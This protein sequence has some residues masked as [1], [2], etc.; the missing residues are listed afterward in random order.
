MTLFSGLAEFTTAVVVALAVAGFGLAW[1]LKGRSISPWPVLG[2]FG[3]FL[4]FGAPVIF[5]GEAGFAGYIKLDDTSTWLAFTDHVLAYGHST[6]GLAPSS[7]EAT[8][9]INL[10]AGYPLGAFIPL[11]VGH[12]LTGT[13]S[14]WLFQPFMAV[15]A[16]L[17][18]LVFFEL[19]RPVVAGVAARSA[20]VFVA[21]QPALLV[22]FAYWGGVKEVATALLVAVLAATIT[23]LTRPE[24]SLSLRALTPAPILAGAALVGVM[25]AGGAPWLLAIALAVA[26]VMA[27]AA[28]RVPNTRTAR[29]ALVRVYLIRGLVVL[30]GVVA[31]GLPTVLAA[32][33]FF[34]PDQGPLTSGGELGNLIEAL[35]PAQYAGPWPVG[36]FRL[37]PGSGLMTAILILATVLA[38]GFGVVAAVK[39]RA[40]ALLVFAF[41]TGLG[42]LIVYAVGSPWIQGK[43]LATGTAS[44]LIMAMAGIGW[45][46]SGGPGRQDGRGRPGPGQLKALGAVLLVVPVAVL[47]SN[48]LAYHESWLSPRAQL[49]ELEGIGERFAGQ[50]PALMT[51]YQP[52][53]VRHFLRRAD[54][55]GASELRRRAIPRRDGSEAEKGAWTDTDGLALAPD[56]EGLLTYPVLVLRR[57]PLQSRPPSP[58]T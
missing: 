23:A 43:A 10:S 2:A 45:L 17:M 49:A 28:S 37:S 1:P 6:S 18:S 40:A 24:S 58:Y 48:A 19:L 5:S 15:M 26:V 11:A 21:A 51:E 4:V 56:R 42:S 22:G 46:L 30:G 3:V 31:I 32:G 34:S 20:L 55:E 27:V 54:A 57:S 47:A 50:G 44:F 13:D 33:S 25:G 53:G 35:E 38:W 39:D 52:Y 29:I 9:Q 12:E 14:A 36:D 16:A 41:G 8:V 7:H